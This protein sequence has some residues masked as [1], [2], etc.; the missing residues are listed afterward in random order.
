DDTIHEPVGLRGVVGGPQL[1]HEL[2]LLAEVDLLQML[3]PG[4]IPEM[5][6]ATVLAAEQNLGNEA[7]LERVGRAPFAGD[8]RVVPQVPPGVVS[9]LLRS[10]LDLPAAE[11]LEAFVIHHE[12]AAGSLP[13]AV[14]ERRD[15]DASGT[16]MR[17]VRARVAGLLGDFSRLDR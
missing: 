1:E 14:A 3:A 2:I 7:V 16:T 13:F 11:R 12:D 15:V 9:E 10:P 5:Q 6:P 4:Q 17:G 8:H